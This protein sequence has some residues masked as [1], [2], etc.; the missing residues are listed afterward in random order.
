M[1]NISNNLKRSWHILWNYKVLW[2]FAFLLAL[3]SGNSSSGSN[4]GSGFRYSQNIDTGTGNFSSGQWAVWMKQIEAWFAQTISPLFATQAKALSTSIWIG[5]GVVLFVIVLSLLFALVRYPAESAIIRMVDEYEFSGT[6]LSFKEGWKLGW[7]RRAFRMAVIDLI[8]SAPLL[9]F[10]AIIIVIVFALSM[11]QAQWTSV[12]P[13]AFPAIL[14]GVL[15]L[16]VF[17][18]GMAFLGLLRNFIIRAAALEDSGVGE[19]FRRGWQVFAD[20]VKNSFLMWLTLLGVDI[21]VGMAM[22]LVVLLLIPVYVVMAIPGAIVAAIPGAIAFGITSI[23]TSPVLPWIIGGVVALP[24]LILIIFSP[25]VLINGLVQLFKSNN[26]TLAYRQFT[27]SE[28]EAP[29][30]SEEIPPALPLQPVG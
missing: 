25:L 18:A 12:P 7:T 9:L 17:V 4:G 15:F 19:S 13:G 20:N 2:I 23:F 16:L 21:G 6:K 24:F 10:I 28:I 30:D 27:A 8:L 26:W 1:F 29:A 3:T 11:N 14:A 5:V 22:I